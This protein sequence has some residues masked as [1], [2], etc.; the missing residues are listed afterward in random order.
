MAQPKLGPDGHP[1]PEKQGVVDAVI[2][3]IKPKPNTGESKT[4]AVG[5][6]L[7]E[8][9]NPI[10]QTEELKKLLGADEGTK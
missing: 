10:D 4:H 5:V 1:I 2:A 9:G 6:A 8:H 7:D 3:P